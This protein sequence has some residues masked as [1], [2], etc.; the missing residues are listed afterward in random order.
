MSTIDD[1]VNTIQDRLSQGLLD[2][3]VSHGDLTDISSTLSG[4][5]PSER[6]Q[7]VSQL[8]ADDLK[9]W[10]QE[11]HGNMGSLSAGERQDLFK[12]LAEGLDGEQ[13]TRVVNAFESEGLGDSVRELGTAVATHADSATKTDFVSHMADRTNSGDDNYNPE[14]TH[15][16]DVTDTLRADPDAQAVAEVLG[17]LEGDDFDTAVGHLDG[18]QLDAVL[19]AGIYQAE[20]STRNGNITNFDST[21]ATR[22]VEAAA[23]SNDPSVKG[24]V[25]TA[26]AERLEL[27]QKGGDNGA[28]IGDIGVDSRHEPARTGLSDAMLGL[29]QSDT[30]GV[31][32]EIRTQYD[33][34]GTS[35][36]TLNRELIGAGREADI[37]NVILQLQQ[38]NDGGGNAYETVAG[39]DVVARN[40]GLFTG[41]AVNAISD[42]NTERKDQ[43][44]TLKGIFGTAYGAA[45][46]ANPGAGVIASVGNG[47][48]TSAI[49]SIIGRFES[50]DGD[51]ATEL[52]Q[53]FYELSIP[54]DAD[55]YIDDSSDS[56][57]QDLKTEF[58]AVTSTDID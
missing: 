45:G 8:E 54:R 5:T 26:A 31:V 33:L 22:I 12:N 21:V 51:T 35:L 6:N 13:L 9:N 1:A 57:I 44:E 42:L 11:V 29:L 53:A 2:W 46:A 17:S 34:S 36:T 40:L 47:I 10:A 43:A 55:G 50:S 18:A 23:T 49:N 38:G 7:V 41:S 52:A 16:N 14:P 58:A 3:D 25:F 27:I 56:T 19:Q 24:A 4:L 48:T 28:V 20:T 30:N 37:R 39:S 15:K 32:T